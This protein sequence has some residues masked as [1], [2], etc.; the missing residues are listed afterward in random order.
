MGVMWQWCLFEEMPR[1]LSVQQ[2]LFMCKHSMQGG[3]S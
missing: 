1:E 3:G 2:L